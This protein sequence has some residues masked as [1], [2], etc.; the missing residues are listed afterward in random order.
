[1]QDR[2]KCER[3]SLVS[4]TELVKKQ[5][6]LAPFSSFLG[7]APPTAM[8][9]STESLLMHLR[10][11]E[12]VFT[13]ITLLSSSLNLAPYPVILKRYRSHTKGGSHRSFGSSR[14]SSPDRSRNFQIK[15]LY[16]LLSLRYQPSSSSHRQPASNIL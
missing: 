1:M 10:S 2:D 8:L 16:Q 7:L 14:A 4:G 15:P 13:P 9:L 12:H 11:W 5:L 6:K 3:K